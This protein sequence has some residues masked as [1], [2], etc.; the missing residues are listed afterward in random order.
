MNVRYNLFCFNAYTSS[1]NKLIG[2]SHETM[3]NFLTGWSSVEDSLKMNNSERTVCSLAIAS[4]IVP[5]DIM[6]TT[7]NKI[8]QLRYLIIIGSV[9]DNLSNLLADVQNLRSLELI[10]I[11]ISDSDRAIT[12][13]LLKRFEVGTMLGSKKLPRIEAIDT[14]T[15]LNVNGNRPFEDLT[16]FL[17]K[18]RNL[19]SLR[20]RSNALFRD[21]SLNQVQFKLKH[22]DIIWEQPMTKQA[23]DNCL[24]FLELQQHSLEHL[25]F[26]LPLTENVHHFAFSQFK[27]LKSLDINVSYLPSNKFFFQ[28]LLPMES[29][30]EL[31]LRGKFQKHEVAKAFMECFPNVTKLDTIELGTVLW[32]SKFLRTYAS[33]Q[34]N[35]EYLA[36]PNFFKGT[37]NNLRFSNLKTLRVKTISDTQLWLNVIMS[38]RGLDTIIVD[39]H[40]RDFLESADFECIMELPN[41]R[42][43]SFNSDRLSIRIIYDVIRKNYKNLLTAELSITDDKISF[44]QKHKINFP[45]SHKSWNPEEF[46][47]IFL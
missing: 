17:I 33:F 25:G 14:L 32:S 22:F 45:T 26:N 37:P 44:D 36:I 43:I 5:T 9:I 46:D 27:Q 28:A 20:V 19:I 16:T 12:M 39:K 40:H 30:R 35:I 11:K 38:H 3:R 10:G 34:K 1:W 18:H 21:G 47:R 4:G 6:R 29:V 7:L 23:E 8:G 15:H 41:L 31:K 24:K 13:P 2:S 42:H